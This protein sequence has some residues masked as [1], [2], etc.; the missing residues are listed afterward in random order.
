[1]I[2]AIKNHWRFKQWRFATKNVIGGE[3]AKDKYN[4]NNSIN[5]INT[6]LRQKVLDQDFMIILVHLF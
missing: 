3:T 1:M 6:N 2:Q 4:Q 5:S